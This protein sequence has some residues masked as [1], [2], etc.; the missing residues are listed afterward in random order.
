MGQDTLAKLRGQLTDMAA[1]AARLKAERKDLSEA[2]TK[3]TFIQPVL[4]TLGWK[5]TDPDEVVL[6]YPVYG[7]T[8]LDYA[9]QAGG[10]PALYLEAKA[11]RASMD[12]PGF[13]AQ[14]VSYA[15]NDGIRWCVLTNGLIY[16]IYKSDALAPADQKLLAEADI[17]EATDSY[18]A[19]RVASTLAYLSKESLVSGKLDEWGQRVF[20]DTAVRK[21]ISSLLL[22]G[23]SALVGLVR[24]TMEEPHA[25]KEIRESFVR[26]SASPL[27]DS[28]SAA[29]AT[30]RTDSPFAAKLGRP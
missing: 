12:E 26:L 9:L 16:R 15:N 18:G 11:L 23:S 30:P 17:R 27:H 2:N 21:A 4:E 7:G 6:E 24:R 29:S 14:T 19:A 22:Q 20:V 10:K 1:L 25:P 28:G 3:V 8:R 13:I 5:V